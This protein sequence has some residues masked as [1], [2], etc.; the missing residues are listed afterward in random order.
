MRFNRAAERNGK[1]Q[2]LTMIVNNLRRTNTR[3]IFHHNND[4]RNERS[5]IAPPYD[6]GG[7]TSTLPKLRLKAKSITLA[8][9]IKPHLPEIIDGLGC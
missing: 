5:W 8:A 1:G 4:D 9:T 7:P 6:A 2:P 3:S